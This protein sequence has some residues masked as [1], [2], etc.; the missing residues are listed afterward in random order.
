MKFALYIILLFSLLSCKTDSLI[1]VQNDNQTS[2]FSPLGYT[3]GYV[4]TKGDTVIPLDK[5]PRCYTENFRYYA[6]VLDSERGLIGIDRNENKLFNSV[7]TGE[8]TP[9]EESEGMIL[10]TENGKY[11][12]A[13]NKGKIVIKPTFNCAGS[14]YQGKAKVSFDCSESN[15]EHFK[16]QMN[17]WFYIDKKG[18]RI[19]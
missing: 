14:F 5:Y 9:I 18:K 11:G 12:Y 13:N 7:W 15:D 8:G 3:S 4:S 10:I 2:K 19:E 16:W 17:N 6:I 1:L